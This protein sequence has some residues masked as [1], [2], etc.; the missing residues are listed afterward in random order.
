MHKYTYTLMLIMMLKNY[1]RFYEQNPFE[2]AISKF[3]LINI[4]R[5]LYSLIQHIKN[6]Q[7]FLT[8]N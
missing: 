2:S 3:L 5:M 8:Y 7:Q 4:L 1:I 6:L